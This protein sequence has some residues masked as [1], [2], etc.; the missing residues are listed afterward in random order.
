MD[1]VRSV[2]RA[3]SD[4]GE[5]ETGAQNFPGVEAQDTIPKCNC[6]RQNMPPQNRLRLTY[7][8]VSSEKSLCKRNLP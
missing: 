4:C 5:E 7:S 2:S 6:R 3:L 8:W 1:A